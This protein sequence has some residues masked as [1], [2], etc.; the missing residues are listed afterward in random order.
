MTN[1]EKIKNAIE[2]DI[3]PNSYYKE[4]I[5]TIEKGDKMKKKSNMWKWSFVP[6]C[7]VVAISSILLIF[8]NKELNSDLLKQNIETKDNVSIYVNDVSK[9]SQGVLRFDVDVEITNIENIS[10]FKEIGDIKIP[11]DF[12]NQEVSAI[13]VK[14][15]TESNEYSN[16]QSYTIN[17][18]NAKND[19]YMRVSFSK[20]NK[21]IRDYY[22][23]ED[24]SK[25]SNI[26]NVELKIFKYNELYFTE[27]NYKDINFD[28]ETTNITEQELTD[29]L[30][31]IIKK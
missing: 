27:F 6:I 25:L 13:Y 24:G 2:E 19:R 1:K 14:P 7:L 29:L 5:R 26:N 11:S 9:M 20:E 4:I 15:D 3:N 30:L 23:S 28:I 17:Y 22:F 10:Y 16:L 31:S 12:D 21:P 18:S 8:D